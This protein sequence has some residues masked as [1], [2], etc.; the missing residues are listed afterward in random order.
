MADELR[1]PELYREAGLVWPPAPVDD[2]ETVH[3]PALTVDRLITYLEHVRRV[4]GGGVVVTVP[5]SDDEIAF[6][7]ADRSRVA[8]GIA[9]LLWSSF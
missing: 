9:L 4:Y 7:A 2:V 5:R 1:L 3:E 8:D 6:V